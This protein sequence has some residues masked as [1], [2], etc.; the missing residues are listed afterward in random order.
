MTKST[1]PFPVGQS[2]DSAKNARPIENARQ[3]ACPRGCANAVFDDDDW[4]H[5]CF[6][7]EPQI[8]CDCVE[9]C[10]D[11]SE[12]QHAYPSHN[13]CGSAESSCGDDQ[14]SCEDDD[15]ATQQILSEETEREI[16]AIQRGFD[17]ARRW[18]SLA[19]VLSTNAA[20]G[21]EA[22]DSSSE[23][24][25]PISH[26]PKLLPI[27]E[28]SDNEDE[29]GG[30]PRS[31]DVNGQTGVLGQ[32]LT[33]AKQCHR[34]NTT[35][36]CLRWAKLA[37]GCLKHHKEHRAAVIDRQIERIERLS[38][39]MNGEVLSP[40][41]MVRDVPCDTSEMWQSICS[42]QQLICV[43]GWSLQ[44][45]AYSAQPFVTSPSGEFVACQIPG[46][47]VYIAD[48]EGYN[49][50]RYTPMT[51][52]E[53]ANV[54]VDSGSSNGGTITP[55]LQEDQPQAQLSSEYDTA[56]NTYDFVPYVVERQNHRTVL[57]LDANQSISAQRRIELLAVHPCE[58]EYCQ[59]EK[60]KAPFVQVHGEE[61]PRCFECAKPIHDASRCQVPNET[62]EA[63]EPTH[64]SGSV[65]TPLA[66]VPG[67][68]RC[69]AEGDSGDDDPQ[70]RPSCQCSHWGQRC[71][72]QARRLIPC[73][74]CHLL[75]C[76]GYCATNHQPGNMSTVCHVCASAN[77][78]ERLAGCPVAAEA[79]GTQSRDESME[80][81]RAILSAF[82]SE[83]GTNDIDNDTIA[84]RQEMLDRARSQ[85]PL[86]QTVTLRQATLERIQA[87]DPPEVSN[88]TEISLS[89]LIRV[90]REACRTTKAN[91]SSSTMPVP[92]YTAE[93]RPDTTDDVS[94][95]GDAVPSTVTV[96]ENDP[97]DPESK[98]AVGPPD[99]EVPV[100]RPDGW[101]SPQEQYTQHGSSMPYSIAQDAAPSG[102]SGANVQHPACASQIPMQ[103][104][105][106]HQQWW[107]DHWHGWDSRD[108]GWGYHDHGE[109]WWDWRGDRNWHAGTTYST[110]VPD[111]CH[112]RAMYKLRNVV[113]QRPP[114]QAGNLTTPPVVRNYPPD[115]KKARAE[116]RA[117]E[118]KLRRS[119]KA[120]HAAPDLWA[121]PDEPR[122]CQWEG[123]SFDWHQECRCCGRI[124]CDNQSHWVASPKGDLLHCCHPD[125]CKRADELRTTWINEEGEWE[126]ESIAFCHLSELLLCGQPGYRGPG[127]MPGEVEP[128]QRKK[129]NLFRGWQA[130]R[131]PRN[132]G[133]GTEPEHC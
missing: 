47:G 8:P 126:D 77:P 56:R 122:I 25:S 119:Q 45:S 100:G 58:Y 26:V 71:H 115:I 51:N 68:P 36:A 30:P 31:I 53:T 12:A 124:L 130:G 35:L 19:D 40:D 84:R 96:E 17:N 55:R 52:G 41:T 107:G 131:V 34:R 81:L 83:D 103:A 99:L 61:R 108:S 88:A 74:T 110:D 85:V 6:Q 62:Q 39:V 2:A 118:A 104:E 20:D 98:Q 4:C 79:V 42:L 32:S 94:Q 9:C 117:Q 132:V 102:L 109:S 44:W 93:P 113:P 80:A 28:L 75:V 129:R 54:A 21:S 127:M 29:L 46:H 59:C 27:L 116:V 63:Q 91:A 123:C 82:A 64:Q 125:C 48:S 95:G 101:R 90:W 106:H 60:P 128:I 73:T 111:S 72:H 49:L 76:P 13:S 97:I 92:A 57:D 89:Y 15:D 69:G 5:F 3:C 43:E 37:N 105:P 87:T 67:I 38:L 11:V 65:N 22:T 70:D 78:Q 121:R 86:D 1:K 66:T 114:T 14:S 33:C 50:L 16:R 18:T 23:A 120:Q 133:K 7:T 24:S 10:Q 112:A